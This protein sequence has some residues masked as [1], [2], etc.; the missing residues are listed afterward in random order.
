MEGGG[1]DLNRKGG[2]NL[3]ESRNILVFSTPRI[4][5]FFT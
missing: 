1:G 3:M 5:F 4:F 2:I